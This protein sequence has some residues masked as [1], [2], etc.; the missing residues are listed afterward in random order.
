MKSG[1]ITCLLFFFPDLNERHFDRKWAINVWQQKFGFFC[2]TIFA[3][4]EKWTTNFPFI[5]MIHIHRY[6]WHDKEC[7]LTEFIFLFKQSFRNNVRTKKWEKRIRSRNLTF[8][9]RNFIWSCLR[10]QTNFRNT[11]L[12]CDCVSHSLSF[13]SHSLCPFSFILSLPIIELLWCNCCTGS[14]RS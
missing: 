9:Q 11:R 8:K 2:Y 14:R 12:L 4:T 5:V 6:E 10:W 1:I 13:L 3:P 7:I